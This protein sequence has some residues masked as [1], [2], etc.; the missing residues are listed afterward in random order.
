MWI[1]ATGEATLLICVEHC[2]MCNGQP[3]QG[4]ACYCIHP[5][6]NLFPE[7]RNGSRLYHFTLRHHLLRDMVRSVLRAYQQKEGCLSSCT[8]MT[9][10]VHVDAKSK[11]VRLILISQALWPSQLSTSFNSLAAREI[12]P[13]LQDPRGSFL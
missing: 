1:E 8:C 4:T 3:G 11:I 6:T 7:V 10:N 5:R 2:I 9:Y 12:I 13:K